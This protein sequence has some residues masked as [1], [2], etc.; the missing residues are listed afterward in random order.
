[1]TCDIKNLAMVPGRSIQLLFILYIPKRDIFCVS[2]KFFWFSH[3]LTSHNPNMG[4]FLTH[5]EELYFRKRLAPVFSTNCDN[6]TLFERYILSHSVFSYFWD[7]FDSNFR[8]LLA[9]AQRSNLRKSQGLFSINSYEET[10]LKI[11]EF[12]C[13]YH[14]FGQF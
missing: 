5:T 2:F 9:H 4:K 11:F 3:N 7:C 6:R 14:T 1:M 8:Q 13:F 10:F 12:V